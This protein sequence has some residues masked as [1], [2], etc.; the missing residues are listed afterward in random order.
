MTRQELVL[1]A[2][3]P[4]QGALHTPVQ[5][6]KL[7]FLIETNLVNLVDDGPH[8]HFEPYHYGPF[9]RAVYD[10]LLRLSWQGYVDIMQD[11]WNSY[12]LTVEGQR[13][14]ERLLSTLD[15]QARDYITTISSFVRSLTF[16]QLVAAIYRAYPAMRERSVFQG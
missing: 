7:L 3:S 9:D 12:R 8:F 2:L 15:E 16:T 14:G 13:Q 5:V 6:Q 11:R 4:A 1:A 10:E